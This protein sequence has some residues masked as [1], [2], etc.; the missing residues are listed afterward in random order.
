MKH[1][2]N[3]YFSRTVAR[4][5]DLDGDTPIQVEAFARHGHV[6]YRPCTAGYVA[7]ETIV[8]AC[9]LQRESFTRWIKTPLS[10]IRKA[11]KVIPTLLDIQLPFPLDKCEYSVISLSGNK[12]RSGSSALVIGARHSDIAARLQSLSA[13]AVDPH[14]LDQEGLCL[15]SQLMEE[16]PHAG[17][18]DVTAALLF[19]AR[20]RV[21]ICIGQSGQ[22]SSAHSLKTPDVDGIQR[23][24]KPYLPNDRQEIALFRAGPSASAACTPLFLSCLA[25]SIP[26]S[27]CTEV[28]GPQAF[29]ARACARRALIGISNGC[30]LRSGIFLNEKQKL[31]IR[32]RPRNT[33]IICLMAG[34]SLWVCN[35]IWLLAR[36]QLTAQMQ[37]RARQLAVSIVGNPRLVPTG[38]ELLAAKRA[39]AGQAKAHSAIMAPFEN[40]LGESLRS[41]LSALAEHRL[42]IESIHFNRQAFVVHGTASEWDA[43]ERASVSFAHSGWTTNLER[44]ENGSSPGQQPFVLRIAPL[45]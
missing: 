31:R 10:S 38:Q 33:A 20:D 39:I 1:N 22:F 28:Q 8:A 3:L 32:R 15:W 40:S 16:Q 44:K 7:P 37:Q 34:I 17:R 12:D 4:G 6:E 45:P 24:I 5:I 36:N 2:L 9:I 14:I 35:G 25:S 18:Q 21:T 11:E 42:R 26:S 27:S 13:A 43:C 41:V 29:L 30:N 19:F 23:I